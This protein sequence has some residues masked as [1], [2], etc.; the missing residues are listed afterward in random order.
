MATVQVQSC[1]SLFLEMRL[2]GKSLSTGTGVV[3]ISPSGKPAL[4]TNW[5]NVTR[6]RPDTGTPLD[7][8]DE[9]IPDEVRIIHVAD[10]PGIQWVERVERLYDEKNRPRWHEHPVHGKGVDAVAVPLIQLGGVKLLPYLGPSVPAPPPIT[11]GPAE[12]VSVIGF[13][14]G[15]SGGGALAIWATGFVASEPQIDLGNLPLF[16]ID[17]RARPGQSGSAVIAFRNGG[18]VAM[19]DGSTAMFN[20]PLCRFLGLYSGRINEQSDLGM[21]WKTSA[22]QEILS[23]M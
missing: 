14:F 8:A 18:A 19:D 17:C 12:V 13:P 21:V 3:G 10:A 1:M 16:L 11:Y 9:R 7:P 20:G 6:R 2:G 5:H 22:L 4:L 15:L 23:V